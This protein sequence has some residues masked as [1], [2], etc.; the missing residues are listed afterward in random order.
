[1]LPGAG[2]ASPRS[3]SFSSVM[4]IASREFSIASSSV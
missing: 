4:L 1:M 2:N 3:T